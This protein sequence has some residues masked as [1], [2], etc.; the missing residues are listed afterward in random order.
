MP[1]LPPKRA[2]T[3]SGIARAMQ[4]YWPRHK[5][6]VRSH[7]CAVTGCPRGPI[8]FAH[9]RCAANSG[10]DDK[11]SDCYGVPLCQYHHAQQHQIGQP[12]FERRHGIDLFELAREFVRRSPDWEMKQVLRP[13]MA[14]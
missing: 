6:F 10:K 4:K 3:R 12:E 8:E 11:P 13:E 14:L 2:R 5:R 1:D 9:V 7:H